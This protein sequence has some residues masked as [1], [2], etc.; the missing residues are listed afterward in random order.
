MWLDIELPRELNLPL[1]QRYF[2]APAGW[3]RRALNSGR[4]VRFWKQGRK[5]PDRSDSDW[6]ETRAWLHMLT[7]T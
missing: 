4:L 6:E 3:Y 2:R 5:V 7:K 1:Y